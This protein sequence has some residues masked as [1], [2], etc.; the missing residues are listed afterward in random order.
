MAL[1]VRAEER[2]DEGAVDAVHIACF[3]TAAEADTVIRLR[4][5][6]ALSASHVAEV[7]GA[8]VGHV[9][10]SP[11]RVE[12][13]A[14]R[15]VGIGPVAV[16]SPWRRR[17]LAEALVRASV[18]ACREAG[19]GFAIVLGDPACYARFGFAPAS[20]FGL[21]DPYGGGDAFQAMEL[22]PGALVAGGGLV[23]YD[24]AF[25]A[26]GAAEPSAR[27]QPHLALIFASGPLGELGLRGGLPW[28][29]PSDRA[30][31]A[32]TTTGHAVVMGRRT[33]EERGRALPGRR[34]IVVSRA[35]APASLEGAEIAASLRAALDLTR[36]AGTMTFVIGGTAL[37]QEAA[38]LASRVY[39][40]AIAEVRGGAD[41]FFRLDRGSFS[42]VCAWYGPAQ[43]RYAILEPRIRPI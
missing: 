42:E 25:A 5:G 17:G 30:Y 1:R 33:W 15:G 10:A 35:L 21:V 7:D 26:A 41:V 36:G 40:T 28:D 13:G 14:S 19:E 8:V 24:G 16:L 43:E 3:P 39:E 2:G 27:E 22:R 18:A 9:A 6:A 29:V 23:R 34:N 11:V 31:F 37:L 12:G 38:P 4:A 32:R 20:R